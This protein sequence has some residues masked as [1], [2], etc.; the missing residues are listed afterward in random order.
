[1]PKCCFTSVCTDDSYQFFI[2]LFVYTVKKAYPD[3]GVKVFVKG[4][5]KKVTSDALKLIKSTDWEVRDKCFS[6]YPN[7]TSMTNSLR[8]L[9]GRKEFEG[10]D[11]V[12]VRDIDFL[13]FPRKLSHMRFFSK[14]MESLPYFGVRGPYSH[15]RRR[16]VNKIGWKGMFTRVAGGTFVFKNPEWFDKTDVLRKRYR[17]KLR[18]QIKY[19]GNSPASYREYDEVMLFRI[20]K[21]SGIATPRRKG[22]DVYGRGMPKVYRDLHLGDF[23][24]NKRGHKRLVRRLSIK[25][26]R[27]FVEL[28]KDPVWKEI[29]KM[30]GKANGKIREILRRVRKH[31]KRRLN[32]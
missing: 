5:L 18:K 25:C 12:F 1:M 10:Y 15:P 27:Q 8:F 13:I 29:R 17:H 31:V 22:K 30:M 14:R 24:K 7:Q 26:A 3:A 11:Y 2:P 28:E 20:L 9:V 6:G 19:E 32:S 23:S 4:H 21:G 16:E